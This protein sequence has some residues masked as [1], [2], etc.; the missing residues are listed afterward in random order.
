ML[1]LVGVSDARVIHRLELEVEDFLDLLYIVEGKRRIVQQP[2]GDD[3]IDDLSDETTDALLGVLAETTAGG[4][5]TVGEHEDPLLL[6]VGVRPW[7]GEGL[8]VDDLVGMLVR[9]RIVE[10]ARGAAPVVRA[11][12]LNDGIG[13]TVLLRQRDPVED[14]ADDGART[15]VVGEVLVGV[16]RSRILREELRVEHLPDIVVERP[17]TDELGI[18]TDLRSG[19]RSEDRDLV[20]VL[21]GPW[22]DLRQLLQQRHIRIAQLDQTHARHIAEDTLDDEGEDIGEHQEDEVHPIE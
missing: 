9:I 7:I 8:W 17:C 18:C 4:L 20:R 1:L 13:Q 15:L 14:V 12:E 5:Y 11:D 6:G 10:V 21:E 16:V 3:T 22:C 19:S 2:F